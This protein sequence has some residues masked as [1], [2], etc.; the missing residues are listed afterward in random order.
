M[1]GKECKPDALKAGTKIRVTTL[2]K[3]PD[4]VTHLEAI[5]SN[6]LFADTHDG[7]V[8]SATA[9]RIVMTDLDGKEHSHSLSTDTKVTCDGKVCKAGDLKSGLRIRVTTKKGDEVQQPAS[10]QSTRT[11]ILLSPDEGDFNDGSVLN[12]PLL[13]PRGPGTFANR[14][15]SEI[16]E[17]QQQERKWQQ[18]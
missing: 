18:K 15:C 12:I 11:V 17:K 13:P 4:A 7:K 3:D 5:E 6:K 8:V 2:S 16:L 1:D 10:K 14:Q 9:G